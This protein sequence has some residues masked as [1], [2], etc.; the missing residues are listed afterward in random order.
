LIFEKD[1]MD[2]DIFDIESLPAQMD[3]EIV[4]EK[5]VIQK[6]YPNVSRKANFRAGSK[7]LMI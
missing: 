5:F 6:N 3:L 2:K 1:E 4:W 7:P